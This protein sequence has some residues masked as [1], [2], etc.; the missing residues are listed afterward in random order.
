MKHAMSHD[1]PL[2]KAKEV[3]EH[4]FD[5]YR[6][7]F[8]DYNPTLTWVSESH[9]NASFEAKGIKLKGAI[10]L[11]PKEIVFEMKVPFVLRIFEK[12]ALEI[13]QRELEHWVG[14]AKA[15]EI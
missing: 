1:L 10:E 15:G 9:A 6:Q 5:A 4:A 3:A 8:A 2:D 12:R 11:R 14:K 13:M 7:R